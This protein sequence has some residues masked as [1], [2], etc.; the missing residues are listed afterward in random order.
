ME[1][2]EICILKLIKKLT[3]RTRGIVKLEFYMLSVHRC[4]AGGSMRACHA[5]GP[6][7]IPG[8]DKFPG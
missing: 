3:S 8:R 7:S 4:G 1:H 5:A 6:N 2:F